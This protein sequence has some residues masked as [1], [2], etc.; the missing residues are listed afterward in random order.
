VKKKEHLKKEKA[1]EKA[2]EKAVVE[3]VEV[4]EEAAVREIAEENVKAKETKIENYFI[5]LLL[6]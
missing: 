3:V 2:Q 6:Q 1:Q 5:F 4:V